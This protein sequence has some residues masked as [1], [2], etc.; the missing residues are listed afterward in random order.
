MLLVVGDGGVGDMVR[1]TGRR[2]AQCSM[3]MRVRVE[4]WSW[5]WITCFLDQYCVLGVGKTA[6]Q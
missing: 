2:G 4:L 1:A 3:R 6:D 5:V